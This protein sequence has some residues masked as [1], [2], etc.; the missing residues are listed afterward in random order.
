MSICTEAVIVLFFSGL[1]Y[2]WLLE[3]VPG[4]CGWQVC[5]WKKEGIRPDD[6]R[7]LYKMSFMKYMDM[8]PEGQEIIEKKS[9]ESSQSKFC[10]FSFYNMG[11]YTCILQLELFFCIK[12]CAA[13]VSEFKTSCYK[14]KRWLYKMLLAKLFDTQNI[15]ASSTKVPDV[16]G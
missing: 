7:F 12:T 11:I 2:H 8:F 4:Y 6:H 13:R 3:N 9:Q 15:H 10:L 5:A 16:I 14:C 1:T